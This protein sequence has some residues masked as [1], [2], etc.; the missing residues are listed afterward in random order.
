[1]ALKNAP[2][3][4]L[5]KVAKDIFGNLIFT[6]RHAR[7]AQDLSFVFPV[8]SMMKLKDL[9]D[10]ADDI[11]MIYEYYEKAAPS[12]VNGMPMF[13]SCHFLNKHDAKIVTAM[14]LEMDKAVKN[15]TGKPSKTNS[16]K[17]RP[18]RVRH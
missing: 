3:D 5:A 14:V 12:S 10:I 18:R 15:V 17:K 4:D 7:S 6:D 9:M 2:P 8:V 11:G 1:M 16:A 13:F